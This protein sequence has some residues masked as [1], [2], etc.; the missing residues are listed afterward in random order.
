MIYN[1]RQEKAGLFDDNR[2]PDFYQHETFRLSKGYFC[3]Q[4]RL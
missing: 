4:E 3:L 1:K 2:E